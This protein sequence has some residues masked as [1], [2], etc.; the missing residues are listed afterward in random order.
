[1]G[2]GCLV[3]T[4]YTQDSGIAISL[5]TSWRTLSLISLSK[6]R[7]PNPAMIPCWLARVRATDD[8]LFVMSPS[9]PLPYYHPSKVSMDL[10]IL[11]IFPS[12]QLYNVPHFI[13]FYSFYSLYVDVVLFFIVF[14]PLHYWH[15]NK[16]TNLC[17]KNSWERERERESGQWCT[18]FPPLCP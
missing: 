16:S 3:Q 9:L 17:S 14:F 13:F 8:F 7:S 1:M 11:V 12:Y 5:Q 15:N 4:R 2:H 6:G 10:L 18:T